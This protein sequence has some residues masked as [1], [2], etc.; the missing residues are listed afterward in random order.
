MAKKIIQQIPLSL[1]EVKEILEQRKERLCD[2][3]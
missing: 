1:P 3:A 2:A